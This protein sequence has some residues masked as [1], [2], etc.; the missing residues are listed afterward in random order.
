MRMRD[1]MRCQ[2]SWGSV[3]GVDDFGRWHVRFVAPWNRVG[4]STYSVGKGE[5][6]LSSDI[7]EC[8]SGDVDRYN[9]GKLVDSPG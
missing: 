6:G 7:L 3:P 2:G 9:N 8:V 1:K 5:F 4:D